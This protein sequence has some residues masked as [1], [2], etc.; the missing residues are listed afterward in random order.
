M[1]LPAAFNRLKTG[2]KSRGFDYLLE[3][4]FDHIPHRLLFFARFLLMVADTCDI[5]VRCY[6]DYQVRMLTLDD[7]SNI[8]GFSFS[9]DMAQRELREGS[10]CVVVIKDGNAVSW[11]WGATG[12]LYVEYCNTVVQ[13]GDD[14]YYTYRLETIPEERFRGHVNT[15]LRTMHEYYGNLNRTRNYTLIS[16]RSASNLKWH[17][18]SGFKMIGDIFVLT[19]CGLRF[20]F[21]R[22][23]PFHG[24]RFTLTVRIPPEGTRQV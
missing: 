4:G 12:S 15:C 17:E 20:C 16:T 22:K 1:D 8:A 5:P 6:A 21:Y 18:R 9:I 10:V 13:T 23:W 2:F 24:K 11:R 19:I 14:G 3:A 7:L